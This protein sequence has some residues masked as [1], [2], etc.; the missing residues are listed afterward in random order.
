MNKPTTWTSSGIVYK[1]FKSLS[2]IIANQWL[3][4][5]KESKFLTLPSIPHFDDLRDKSMNPKYILNDHLKE[6]LL[7]KHLSLHELIYGDFLGIQLNQ[8]TEHLNIY[9]PDYFFID[10][11]VVEDLVEYLIDYTK[12]NTFKKLPPSTT[13]LV[14]WVG[15]DLFDMY[16]DIFEGE[17][18]IG[19]AVYDSQSDS[20]LDSKETK[21]FFDYFDITTSPNLG[22]GKCT[23]TFLLKNLLWRTSHF[24]SSHPT[25]GLLIFY[26][27]KNQ[28]TQCLQLLHMDY[29]IFYPV[30]TKKPLPLGQ[31]ALGFSQG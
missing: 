24:S 20:F 28:K 1:Y 17:R 21:K 7:S 15:S 3:C 14:K 26:P 9:V 12:H 19:Q 8:N 6:Y 22:T 25:A 5:K 2:T 13:L 30:S 27:T 23:E 18:L 29:D 11:Y 16:D 10:S 4:L 31:E